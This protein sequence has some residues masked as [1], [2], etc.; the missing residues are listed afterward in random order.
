V[1]KEIGL[2]IG[3]LG[4]QKPVTHIAA[5]ELVFD[6]QKTQIDA[7]MTEPN[8]IRTAGRDTV[9]P[10][11]AD[12][13]RNRGYL[14]TTNASLSSRYANER[15]TTATLARVNM[16]DK[17]LID[18]G[19]GD[20]TFTVELFDRG[21]PKS[22]TAI[23]PSEDAIRIAEEKKGERALEF[24]TRS[25][26]EL[27]WADNSFDVAYL[28][29]VLHHLERPIDALREAFRL[30]PQIIVIE[31]NGYNAGLKALE[32]LSRYHIEH[33]EKSYAP[34]RL[35]RWV[36]MLGGV[37]TSRQWIGLVPMF[38]PD[39]LARMLKRLEPIVERVPVF[40]RLCCAQYVF[41][42]CRPV[43]SERST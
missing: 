11:S 43:R 35:D 40:N 24:S 9:A 7:A 17:R 37:I 4:F 20:G 16:R 25:A 29:A 10:F 18:I 22:I 15:M 14:Y 42:A 6:R 5:G 38:C 28:R 31:P 19:C 23:D 2:R 34:S 8:S 26:Y 41:T 12:A 1:L 21:R 39:W 3:G 32:R 30:A 36:V 33:E 13:S 27:P